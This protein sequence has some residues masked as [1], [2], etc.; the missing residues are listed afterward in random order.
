MAG[1]RGGI[2]LQPYI[3]DEMGYIGTLAVAILFLHSTKVTAA[4]GEHPRIGGARNGSRENWHAPL[5]T[6]RGTDNVR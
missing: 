4:V 3:V 6:C 1:L 2:R 5:P